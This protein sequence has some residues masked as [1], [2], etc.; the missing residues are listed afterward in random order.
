MFFDRGPW[1]HVCNT[2]TCTRKISYLLVF[3]EK[4][5]PQLPVQGKNIMFSGKNTIFWDNTIK[6]ISQRGPFWKDHLFR[7]F[8][9]NIIFPCIF[10]RK[11][12]FHFQGARSYFR[13]KEIS[14]SPIIQE[15]SYFSPIFLEKPSFQDVWKKKIWF[16]VKCKDVWSTRR[17]PST[18]V[19][20]FFHQKEDLALTCHRII[21]L[22]DAVVFEMSSKFDKNSSNSA[23]LWLGDL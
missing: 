15:R 20:S 6:I 11:I 19:L 12:I 4:S 3:P 9:G 22:G 7:T 5:H 18:V 14:S 16:S 8:E 10:L 23:L 2:C 13:E 1:R 21:E 17:A